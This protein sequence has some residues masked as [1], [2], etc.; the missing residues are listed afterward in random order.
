MSDIRL[1]TITIESVSLNTLSNLTIQNGNILITNT[2]VSTNILNGVLVTDGGI[3]INCTYDSIS[4]TSGGAL[5]IGGGIGIHGQ[6]FLGNNLILDNNTSIISVKGISNYR[7]FLDTVNNKNF[8]LALDGTNKRFDLY[9]TYLK[10][11]ITTNSTNITTG[12]F[13][14]NG[15]I[16]INS[17]FNSVNS[18][19]GGALTIGGGLAVGGDSY[20]SKTLTIGQ[21]GSLVPTFGLQ[22]RY[23]G[24][25]QSQISLQNNDNTSNATLNMNGS[26]FVTSNLNDY[27]FNTSTGNF[28]F[29]NTNCTLL[30]M[31]QSYSKFSKYVIINDTIESLNLTSGSLVITGGLS[32]SCTTDS[33]S[34]TNGGCITIGGGLAIS[35]KTFTG[36]SIGI[37]L[38]N[39]NKNNKLMLY[40][41]V[42]NLNEQNVFTGI[43]IT[44][45]SSTS[46][47]S[48]R[49][50][51]PSDTTD[52]IFYSSTSS[53]T[54]SNEV[55]RIKGT[56]E[57][58]FIGNQQRYSIKAGGYTVN[59][60]SIQ[61]QNVA[62]G[63]CLNLYTMDGDAND[64]C[65]LKIFGLG[66][67]NNVINSEFLKIGWQTTNTEFIISTNNRGSGIVRPLVL[68]TNQNINQLQLSTNGSINLSSTNMSI[69]SSTGCLVLLSGG[70]SINGT[71]D[72]SSL[73]N[74]G[75]ITTNG[76]MSIKKSIYVG[77][78]LN[79]YSTNGNVQMYA[80]NN[81]DL[82]LTNPTN[83][84]IFS[85]NTNAKYS[86]KISL[87]TL[88]DT[89][90]YE[91]FQLTTT[92]T[93]GTGIY[94]INSSQS[95]SGILRPIQINV[96][97]N[98]DIFMN[99]NGNV[100]IN[101][102]NPSYNLDINGTVQAN[103]Y[104]YFN[105]LTIYNQNDSTSVHTSGSLTVKGGTSIEKSLWVG[106]NVYFTNTMDSSSTSASVYMSGGL[107]IASGQPGN[108][109]SGALTVIGGASFGQ[110]IFI[111]QD[112]N[113][114]GSIN[115]AAGSS[116]SFAYIS[117]TATDNAI[118][119]STGSL[120]TF[121]GIVSQSYQNS[122]SVSNGGTIL[123]PGGVSI[124]KDLYL[125][126]NMYNYGIT[127]YN[128][129]FNSSNSSFIKIYDISNIQCFSID[130][131]ITSADFS[132][133]RYNNS[134]SFVEKIINISRST[135]ILTINNTI[136]SLN[137]TSGSILMIGGLT[138]K[139]TTN[140]TML[141]SGGAITIYGGASINK[142]VFIGGMTLI[143]STAISNN[144][145]QGA[146]VVNGGVGI[147][148]NL[149]ILGNTVITG[150]LSINGTVTSVHSTNTLLSDNIIVLNSG[151]SGTADSGF[152]TQRYQ[153]DNDNG[154]GDVVNDQ[155]Y[156]SFTLPNQSGMTNIQ[157]K[158]PASA[159]LSDSYYNNWWV[160]ITSGFSSNQVR[161]IIS[162]VGSTK[163]ATIDLAW[164][165]QN[166]N[167]GD[168]IN[169][170][171]RPYVGV[172]YNA[173]N[174]RFEFGSTTQ[175]PGQT[176]VVFT[177]HVPIY[178]D[179]ATF[180]STNLSVNSTSGGLLINGG[181]SINST[182]DASSVT[183]GNGLTIV[184]GASIGKTLYVGNSIYVNNIN[185]QPNQYDIPS[186]TIFTANNNVT[187][188]NIPNLNFGSSVWGFDIY[189][190]IQLTAIT[191]M[192]SNYQIR[193]VNQGSTWQIIQ[194]YVGD[195]IVTFNIT[196]SGQL[197]Y[198]CQSYTGFT[199]LI[200]KFKVIT[201]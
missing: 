64:N 98:T 184:G 43:G 20:L 137:Q 126:G 187:N 162:Y 152:I 115:G 128:N 95:G 29:N 76:G 178:A 28:T 65:D 129:N 112:L 16:S 86:S 33:I 8:Y 166:P 10:I 142:D 1:K 144:Q 160:K 105:S 50:Q 150:N 44:S 35:K 109:G 68:Q 183:C 175:D 134:G 146:L 83:N 140:S 110:S 154:L 40:Q 70:I 113:V 78:T 60:L 127:N 181:V 149:N 117:V 54:S 23:L 39:G 143:S 57:V 74:G 102:T 194:S 121:G 2:T 67:P 153:I 96:G 4:S 82:I 114:S 138:I 136:E 104:N 31:Y 97:N 130:R 6:T 34:Y 52:Y 188:I 26:T 77:N 85:A 147:T 84:Y 122:T 170:Y 90:N 66:L 21:L 56:N 11:N 200:F 94:N 123:T 131:S 18:S 159:N 106:G 38:L 157:L 103:S 75:S 198:S 179:S 41:N 176:S 155:N 13:I 180:N 49:F 177:E 24:I 167:L 192:Y 53:G 87:Y 156:L 62:T 163:I 111:A 201:N 172:I 22:V 99:T 46:F 27:I 148:G 5:T 182:T 189:L 73:T 45:G 108:I 30:T 165:T 135:G 61:S 79:I 145:N 58:Q 101:T 171:D 107:T 47:G 120:V 14:I 89:L 88:N 185:Y 164:N 72:V 119:L 3:G 125:G 199:S 69:N 158:L 19:N 80:A 51:V 190:S 37:E 118:N 168:T 195:S 173:V 92:N 9:D 63:S 133:S 132:I 7:L 193:G 116:N 169:L 55:F 59:D 71:Q 139:C 191:N 36:D 186:T 141:S 93:N 42:N 151:P 124:G 100:G 17:T 197:Q 91:I 196:S 12:A 81:G 174:T 32:I 48:M 161:K 25:G 15:G